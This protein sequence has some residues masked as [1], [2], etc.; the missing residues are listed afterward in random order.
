MEDIG[1]VV[2]NEAETVT[3]EIA[4]DRASLGFG[5]GLDRMADIAGRRAGADDVDPPHHGV[6]RD[7]TKSPGFDA[8][9][10]D[11]E[12]AARIAV[13]AIH[14]HSDVDVYDVAFLE[15]L[16]ARNPVADDVIDRRADGL[17]EAAIVQGSWHGPTLHDEL[18][19]RVIDRLGGCSG[20]DQRG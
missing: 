16:W 20:L 13:P 19:G 18:V 15:G 2:E 6:V 5:I 11:K 9:V 10:A 17:G 1:G 7:V 4:H 14:D 12:H 3:A 8:D